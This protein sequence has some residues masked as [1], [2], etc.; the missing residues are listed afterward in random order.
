[1]ILPSRML[2]VGVGNG[3]EGGGVLKIVVVVLAILLIGV[4][5]E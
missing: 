2:E 5:A 3:L 1:M 4:I